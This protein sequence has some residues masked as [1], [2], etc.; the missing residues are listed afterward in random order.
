MSDHSPSISIVTITFNASSVIEP[1]LRSIAS[2]TCRDFEHI[3]IDGA[4]ADN[5]LSLCRNLSAPDRPPRI[6][7]ERDNGLYDAMNKGIAMARGRY[8]LFLNAGDAFHAD[9]TLQK[10]RDAIDR[11]VA[12]D[13]IYAD[14]DIVDSERRFIAPRHLSAPEL[15]SF[16]SFRNGMLVCH[17][18][19]MVRREI[20]PLYNLQYRFSADYE[21]C[22]RILQST[23]PDRCVNLHTVAIDYLSDGLTDKNK[24]KS[25][26]E[27]YAIMSNYYGTIP[28]AV[29]H[30]KFAARALLRKLRS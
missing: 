19:F 23:S 26:K 30:L 8:L 6:L 14:T 5:T 21:W 20:A 11:P 25:L 7:S 13:V 27:R 24:T 2:Q 17:Q 18:A 1:T 10:Y 29:M 12:P 16:G 22:L 3:I 28:T 4:S 9:D 15:L